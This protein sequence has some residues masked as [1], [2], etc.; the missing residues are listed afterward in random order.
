V[1]FSFPR[2]CRRRTCGRRSPSVSMVIPSSC[3]TLPFAGVGFAYRRKIRKRCRTRSLSSPWPRALRKAAGVE[4]NSHDHAVFQTKLI[5]PSSFLSVTCSAGSPGRGP[6][7][8]GLSGMD[9]AV[10]FRPG[11]FHVV[12]LH[13]SSVSAFLLVFRR[14]GPALLAV[15]VSHRQEDRRI[16]RVHRWDPSTHA[17]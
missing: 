4:P 8:T 2:V 12:H 13:H 1:I 7:G 17:A 5:V 15:E 6:T 16:R 3:S 10:Y 9:F 14:H 11:R